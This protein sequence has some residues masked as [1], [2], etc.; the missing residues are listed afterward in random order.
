MSKYFCRTAQL[1]PCNALLVTCYGPMS[2]SQFVCLSDCQ[3][4]TSV[5]AAFA[6]RYSRLVLR[7]CNAVSPRA[8]SRAYGEWKNRG[9]QNSENI[10]HLTIGLY[11][12][13]QTDRQ[14]DTRALHRPYR[15]TSIRMDRCLTTAALCV[16]V[17]SPCRG[18]P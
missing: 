5:K 4:S 7:P 8:T 2:V 10:K 11:V 1:L 12:H 16:A 14:T 13:I 17:V 3:K 6:S 15:Q 18:R 9:C